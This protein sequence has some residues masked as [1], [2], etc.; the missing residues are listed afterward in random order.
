MNVYF[1]Y[2]VTELQE[3]E[4]GIEQE[5]QVMRPRKYYYPLIY[6]ILEFFFPFEPTILCFLYYPSTPGGILHPR[7]IRTTHI[8]QMAPTTSTR[9]STIPLPVCHG[10]QILPRTRMHPSR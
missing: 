8:S 1:S 3:D 10:S 5:V 9:R 6:N 4:Y 7:S 2:R